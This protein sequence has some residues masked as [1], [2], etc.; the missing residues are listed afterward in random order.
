MWKVRQH[1]T[2]I[3][4][5]KTSHCPPACNMIISWKRFPQYCSFVR[6]IRMWAVSLLSVWKSC[7]T[8]NRILRDLRRNAWRSCE[9]RHWSICLWKDVETRDNWL[10]VTFLS[11]TITAKIENKT[12]IC[13]L[14]LDNDLRYI[15]TMNIICTKLWKYWQHPVDTNKCLEQVYRCRR[16]H[17]GLTKPDLM[18]YM[19]I[20]TDK[21]RS[22][23][24][25]LFYFT[26]GGFRQL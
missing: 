24:Y 4:R 3:F 16:L 19:L 26:T 2:V 14:L 9:A 1:E 21:S 23:M 11:N 13:F 18:F 8:S 20:C 25:F 22:G 10:M 12:H 7:W 15:L 5:T 6:K 17:S